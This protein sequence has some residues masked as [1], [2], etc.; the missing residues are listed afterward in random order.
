MDV[1][2]VIVTY[3]VRPFIKLSLDSIY[4]SEGSLQYEVIIVDNQS[5]DGSIDFLKT[6]PQDLHFIENVQNVGFS[7]ACNQGAQ[8]AKGDLLIF[9]NPDTLIKEDLVY[10][11]HQHYKSQENIGILGGR[12]YDGGLH[13]LPESKRKFPDFWNSIGRVL[14]V[15]RVLPGTKLDYYDRSDLHI[16]HSIDVLTGAFMMISK[17]KFDEVNGFEE[18]YFMY[19]ED[20]DIS[21][22]M[23]S[24]G[25][26][27]QYSAALELIHFK[28]ESTTAK[29]WSYYDRFYGAMIVYMSLHMT[30]TA[31]W[32]RGIIA[33]LIRGFSVVKYTI[34]KIRKPFIDYLLLLVIL[35]LSI[36]FWAGFY[37][38]DTAYYPDHLWRLWLLIPLVWTLGLGFYGRYLRGVPSSFK[39]VFSGLGLGT[40]LMI[41]IY[42]MLPEHFRFSRVLLVLPPVIYSLGWGILKTIWRKGE[43]TSIIW[44]EI[45]LSDRDSSLIQNLNS[46][47]TLVKDL[48]KEVI[49]EAELIIDNSSIGISQILKSKEL[50]S[51]CDRVIYWDRNQGLF[52]NSQDG[53]TKGLSYNSLSHYNLSNPIFLMHKRVFDLLILLVLAPFMPFICLIFMSITPYL[54][55]MDVLSRKKTIVGYHDNNAL[56]NLPP[57]CVGLITNDSFY[58]E[59]IYSSDQMDQDYALHYTFWKDIV[60]FTLNIFGLII[61][62]NRRHEG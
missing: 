30:S 52:F 32:L 55:W 48:T 11:A 50:L 10:R 43:S 46:S 1:S 13:Y 24:L 29:S 5:N 34:D 62:L 41:A 20:I 35:F 51:S 39:L 58:K 27:N 14:H 45:P 15:D 18:A 7:K 8:I 33:V 4:A 16:D 49:A 9:L 47:F 61:A 12:L 6:Y 54:N 17:A 26:D 31:S 36:R 2:I 60:C 25:Y 22:K 40:L 42:A 19:G 23:K 21:L 44:S 57:I 53:R 38:H 37:Y 28:G 59:E 56:S 3:N